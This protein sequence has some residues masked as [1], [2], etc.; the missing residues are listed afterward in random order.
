MDDSKY[1]KFDND[2]YY[3]HLFERFWDDVIDYA[4]ELELPLWYV[5]EEFIIDGELI[6]MKKRKKD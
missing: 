1:S 6:R 4:N 2:T 5:E 3:E